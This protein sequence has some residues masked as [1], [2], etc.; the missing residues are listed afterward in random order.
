[1]F[2]LSL[3]NKFILDYNDERDYLIKEIIHKT[4]FLI[5]FVK[6]YSQK[7]YEKRIKPSI[8]DKFN[9]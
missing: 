8:S 2:N 7:D 1:M 6:S 4:M 9:F 3:R 5:D